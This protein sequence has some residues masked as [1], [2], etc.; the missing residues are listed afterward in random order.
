MLQSLIEQAAAIIMNQRICPAGCERFRPLTVGL[1]EAGA[2]F[3]APPKMLQNF[4]KTA[5]LIGTLVLDVRKAKMWVCPFMVVPI[6]RSL[7]MPDPANWWVARENSPFQVLPEWGEMEV[8]TIMRVDMYR[9]GHT[10]GQELLHINIQHLERD[11]R[12]WN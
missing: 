2:I 10:L 4:P 11:R 6:M 12:N 1:P 7:I 8:R 3:L 9:A 5:T